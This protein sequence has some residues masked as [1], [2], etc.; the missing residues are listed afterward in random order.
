M[1]TVYKAVRSSGTE[2]YSVLLSTGTGFHL[3]YALNKT[4]KPRIG[5]IFVFQDPENAVKFARIMS[6]DVVLQCI[7]P[8]IELLPR[9][10]I[11]PTNTDAF[12]EEYWNSKNTQDHLFKLYAAF[13]P[14]KYP[15]H[16]CPP[17]G[18]FVCPELTPISIYRTL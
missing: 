2:Y 13:H 16:F 9:W 10:F 3:H 15:D 6:A 11:A 8:N 4:T 7:T 17:E 12:M 1:K 18:T 14:Y 5:K